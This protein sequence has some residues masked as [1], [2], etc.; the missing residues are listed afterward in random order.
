MRGITFLPVD[1][2]KS[3]STRFTIEDGSIRLPLVA[4]ASL[5]DAAALSVVQA[6]AEQPFSS[7]QDLRDRTR[8]TRSHIDIL[9]DTGSLAVY[10]KRISCRCS[11][12]WAPCKPYQ[13]VVY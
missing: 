11:S 10:L 6:R 8:L 2:E 1:I 12:F 3:W 4:V 7:I 5:G 13:P 9:R